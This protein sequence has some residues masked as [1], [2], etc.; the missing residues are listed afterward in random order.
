MIVQSVAD[1]AN[2]FFNLIQRI[3]N[4]SKVIF[5]APYYLSYCLPKHIES[6]ILQELGISK[7]TFFLTYYNPDMVYNVRSCNQ[8]VSAPV[9]KELVTFNTASFPVITSTVSYLQ[10]NNYEIIQD[11]YWNGHTSISFPESGPNIIN[12]NFGLSLYDNIIPRILPQIPINWSFVS[13]I[14]YLA[15]TLQLTYTCNITIPVKITRHKIHHPHNN[16]WY[17]VKH[18]PSNYISR[19]VNVFVPYVYFDLIIQLNRQSTFQNYKN[20]SVESTPYIII[21]KI[22]VCN[23]NEMRIDNN[24]GPYYYDA[25]KYI[26]NL[27]CSD[28]YRWGQMTNC[29][30]L[31]S[32]IQINNVRYV[33]PKTYGKIFRITTLMLNQTILNELKETLGENNFNRLLFNSPIVLNT[34]DLYNNNVIYLGNYIYQIITETDGLFNNYFP[35]DIKTNISIIIPFSESKGDKHFIHNLLC[36]ISSKYP[37]W[38]LPPRE[39]VN[40]L[41]ENGCALLLTEYDIIHTETI[42]STILFIEQIKYGTA[43]IPILELFR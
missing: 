5:Y 33:T 18:R 9:I 7:S 24:T 35:Y 4:N 41:Y 20:I 2:N 29:S 31:S 17:K 13:Y 42:F 21:P 22:I 15:T 28:Q 12:I 39:M 14:E 38:I 34:N 23:W 8:I 26:Y 43:Q 16:F 27:Q 37:N 11:Q 32:N 1:T 36:T 10:G 19:D 25:S 3:A 30:D 6:P 40:E